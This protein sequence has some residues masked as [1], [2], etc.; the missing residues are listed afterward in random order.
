MDCKT[1]F[2]S[3][4]PVRCQLSQTCLDHSCLTAAANLLSFF[5][6][7][8]LIAFVVLSRG[9]PRKNRSQTLRIGCF[10]TPPF[11]SWTRGVVL[12]HRE[13]LDGP[14]S[15]GRASSETSLASSSH[16]KT[17][18]LCLPGHADR[19][20]SCLSPQHA[21]VHVYVDGKSEGSLPGR[22]EVDSA[23]FGQ[24]RPSGRRRCFPCKRPT[25]QD[26][27]LFTQ[28]DRSSRSSPPTWIRVPF[29]G[30]RGGQS[31]GKSMRLQAKTSGE[32]STPPPSFEFEV[33][34]SACSSLCCGLAAFRSGDMSVL[35]GSSFLPRTS[36]SCLLTRKRL[37][38][39]RQA[40]SA[41]YPRTCL[42]PREMLSFS[43]GV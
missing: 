35:T 27:D 10:G 39:I 8:L 20:E 11:C 5:S 15:H 26:R 9:V 3:S 32:K 2:C 1:V 37:A 42:D 22:C 16:S 4:S 29:C 6:L 12:A 34:S 19:R 30:R 21:A 18:L 14:L 36:S 28:G 31:T 41:H 43:P 25:N 24:G 7:V 38:Q 13:H 23:M 33:L 40:P 17:H